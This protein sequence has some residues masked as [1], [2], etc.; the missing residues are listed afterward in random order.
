MQKIKIILVDDHQIIRDGIRALFNGC[1]DI[2]IIAEAAD[3]AECL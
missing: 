2:E 3:A 1:T